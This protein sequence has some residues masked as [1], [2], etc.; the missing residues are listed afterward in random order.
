MVGSIISYSDLY[1][2]AMVHISRSTFLI[3]IALM[4]AVIAA[5][6][7]TAAESPTAE[8]PTAVPPVASQDVDTTRSLI[9]AFT[10]SE[11]L[12]CL[13]EKLGDR[14]DDDWER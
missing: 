7:D 14:F 12:Q 9:D 2:V 5:A 1:K 8:S 13:S 6:C 11:V 10:D 4:I 3:C